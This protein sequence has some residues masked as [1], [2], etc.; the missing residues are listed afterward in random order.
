[1][2][3]RPQTR[4]TAPLEREQNR[5]SS[6]HPEGQRFEWPDFGLIGSLNSDKQCKVLSTSLQVN[7]HT[8]WFPRSVKISTDQK[9]GLEA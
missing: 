2:S 3:G 9:V 1:M 5:A 8:R 7:P 4:P 6:L